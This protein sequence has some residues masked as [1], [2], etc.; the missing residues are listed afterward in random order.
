M[1]TCPSCLLDEGDLRLDLWISFKAEMSFIKTHHARVFPWLKDG[2]SP[3]ILPTPLTGPFASAGPSAWMSFIASDLLYVRSS[4]S[5]H[6]VTPFVL[7]TTWL[8]GI[9]FQCIL[10]VPQRHCVLSQLCPQHLTRPAWNNKH[11]LNEQVAQ[12]LPATLYLLT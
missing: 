11:F 1:V 7:S 8:G 9:I 4:G 10:S 2:H 3:A 12:T 6:L 5:L